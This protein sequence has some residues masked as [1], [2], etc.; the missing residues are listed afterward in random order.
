MNDYNPLIVEPK[1]QKKWLEEK[2]YRAEDSSDKPKYYA[3]VEFPYCSGEGLHIGHAF[4]N[5]IM[6]V[7]ARKKRM[8]GFNVMHPMG[9][10]SFGLPTENYAVKTGIQP[11]VITDRNIKR[12]KETDN[13]LGISYDWE[14]EIDTSN[15]DYYKWTQWIFLQFYK[16]GLA[17]KAETPVG[18]CPS[19]KS[20]LANEEIVNGNCERCGTQAE[21]KRQS[22]WLLKIT[23]YADRLADE[24]DLVDYPD[25]VKASQ[26]N[27]IGKTF[28][29]NI[30]YPV[31]D[32]DMVISCYSTRPDT[33]FG[34]TFVVIAPEHPL[35][36][37]LTTAENKESVS[38]YLKKAQKKSEMERT[39]LAKEKTGVFI[40]SYCLNRL[41]NKKMPI[42]VADFAILTA[43]TGIVVGVPAHDE[44]D[45]A[46][47]KK[48]NLE[49]I[50]V[51][52]SKKRD[53]DFEKGPLTDIDDAFVFNSDFL[54]EMP[55]KEAIEKVINF[56]EEKGWGKRAINY[57]LRDW[58]FSRQHYW[59][60]PIPMINCS[61]CG[62]VPVPEDQ[63]PVKL[64]EVEKY[65]PTNTG[66]SPLA[67]IKEWVE[68]T[69]P[70]CG[71]PAR[72]ETDTMPQ[73]AGSSWYYLRYCDPNNQKQLADSQLLDYWLPVDLYIG[74][75]EHN[76]LHLLYSRFWHKFLND[77]DLVPGK[78]PYASRRQHGIILGE[79]GFK[80]SKSRGNVINP[81]DMVEKIGADALR[82]Y[83]LFMGPYESTMP[84]DTKGTEGTIR[85][86]NRVWK[87]SQEK[88]STQTPR[89][90]SQALAKT[91]KKV[92]EDLDNFKFNTAIAAMMEFINAWQE[93]KEGLSK[94]DLKKFILILAPL[95]PHLAEELWSLIHTDL[96]T[97]SRGSAEISGK[98]QWKS[99]H[100]QSWPTFDKTL[101]IEDEV[102]IVV[103]VNGKVR[104][105]IKMANG[106]WKME[107]KAV[108][109]AKKE[110]TVSKFLTGEPKKVIFIPGKLINFVI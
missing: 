54:N 96:S 36:S 67:N 57:H 79:D 44:R 55:V 84:W 31:V 56:L 108:E 109:Q 62:L 68:T 72:R 83:L 45:Y 34:A 107:N 46:F 87:L 94:D 9:W 103:Q 81:T 3:L 14:R 61:K 95:A 24:L 40:G 63:L 20:I 86:L 13:K 50:P 93:D 6:D 21:Y 75:A 11:Q 82:L 48:F 18:W 52:K 25:Y 49:I 110:G 8:T 28:G 17:Y 39:D 15:P 33:N 97:D 74:G 58:V 77:L 59:G 5:T 29:V 4:T 80:M 106:E 104:G 22:Q 66:E 78:E 16:K 99:V 27:W 98:N 41:N 51:I 105:Q 90:L 7:V 92:G 69:C 12:F 42:Y 35:V 23:A 1:W 89:L 65:Q 32:S 43:G 30:D 73:W 101:L 91:I 88:I 100:K 37:R 47:A 10:D 85:F 19:C 102:T 2:I 26:R 53:W 38:E 60:E 70:E 76:T 64:P 71:G